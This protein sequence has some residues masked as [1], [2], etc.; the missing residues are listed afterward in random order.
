[1]VMNVLHF[2]SM[3]L[4]SITRFINLILFGKSREGKTASSVAHSF[5]APSA[6]YGDKNNAIGHLLGK[7][8]PQTP[9]FPQSCVIMS[10]PLR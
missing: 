4:V 8:S 1:M 3:V 5:G 7:T 6:Y 10:M 2:N 9:F